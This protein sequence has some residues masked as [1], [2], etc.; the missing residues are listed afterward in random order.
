MKFSSIYFIVSNIHRLCFVSPKYRGKESALTKETWI[1][2]AAKSPVRAKSSM[3]TSMSMT[4]VGFNNA[5]TDAQTYEKMLYDQLTDI[6]EM[7]LRSNINK[8]SHDVKILEPHLRERAMDSVD[9]GLAL[10]TTK[11]KIM[12]GD[13]PNHRYVL[14]SRCAA[15]HSMF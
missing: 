2:N 8:T 6:M 1:S 15:F 11:L 7:L 5:S 14:W 10:I 4:S 3:K 13:S 9:E 12:Q